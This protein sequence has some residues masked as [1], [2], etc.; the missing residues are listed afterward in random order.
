MYKLLT[1]HNINHNL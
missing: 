1:I